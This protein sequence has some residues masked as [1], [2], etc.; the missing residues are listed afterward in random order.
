MQALDEIIDE[1]ANRQ[2]LK[3]Q[4]EMSLN[5]RNIGLGVF[6]Y[7][8]MLMKME[9]VYGS[10]KAKK[11]T[12]EIFDCM[13]R[14]AVVASARLAQE[15]GCFPKYTDAVWDSEIIQKHFA[16]TEINLLKQKGLRNCSLLSIAPAGTIA[17][18]L[19]C[20]G[21]CEPE[22]AIKYTRKTVSATDDKETYYDIYCKTAQEYL[23]LYPNTVELPE[24]FI[25]SSQ[26]PWKDRV[27]TQAIMQNHVDT[28][29]SSTVNLPHEATIEDVENLFLY[30]WEQGLK[31]ITIFRDNCKKA[32]VL[33]TSPTTSTKKENEVKESEEQK[34]Q[35]EQK[36]THVPVADNEGFLKDYLPSLK[37]KHEV[38][39]RGDIIEA[40]DNVI[41]LK[42]KLVTGCGSLHCT[43][44]FDPDTGELLE[45]YF[46]KGSSGGCV[47]GDTEFFNGVQWKK[48]AD[49]KDGDYVLQYNKNGIA[50]LVEPINYIV[51]DNVKFLKHFKN[52]YIDMILSNDHRMYL[53]TNFRKYDMGIRK[54]L[55]DEIITVQDWIDSGKKE[56]HMPTT[57]KFSGTGIPLTDDEIKLCV[58]IYA[59]GHICN[60]KS[61]YICVEVS[62]DRKK[63]RV[64]ELLSKCGIQY[65]EFEYEYKPNYICFKFYSPKKISSWIMDKQFS[66]KWYLATNEQLRLVTNEIIYWDG[67]IGKGNRGN[68]YYSS[69]KEEADFIQ[70]AF[71]AI[72]KRATISNNGK[73]TSYRVRTNDI[74][75]LDISKTNITDINTIDSKSYC[76]SVPS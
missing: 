47:S 50:N 25:T 41:G 46:N 12:D 49:Y 51:N 75:N 1:N 6:G 7:A 27:E 62:K 66:C 8:N 63:Q 13:F 26:I 48:I 11:L 21:G 15:K 71:S 55:H 19:G 37:S 28:A 39:Q 60:H 44:Y 76:F 18:T 65:K 42:R 56:R 61:E 43:A 20:S 64:R 40:D 74:I 2:P 52:K 31:G 54:E 24:Y 33:T 34:E 36:T 59:D 22:F 72:G 29:I 38:L 73:E 17:T 58:M 70:F 14:T 5:Y 9:L 35:K 23:N 45:T 16:Q 30:A 10:E 3:E 4:R 68:E 57:F 69:K 67:S 32:G 53:Y